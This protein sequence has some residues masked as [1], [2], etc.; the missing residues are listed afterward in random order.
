MLVLDEPELGRSEGYTR[1]RGTRPGSQITVMPQKTVA[2]MIVSHPRA[3]DLAL[4]KVVYTPYLCTW[5]SRWTADSGLKCNIRF[6]TDDRKKA[7]AP[8]FMALASIGGEDWQSGSNCAKYVEDLAKKGNA[9]KFKGTYHGFDT[10]NK[11]AHYPGVVSS[12][13]HDMEV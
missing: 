1:A 5:A 13:A 6:R 12:K 4:Q 7:T 8:I 10:N 2:M 11:F 3:M 9:I